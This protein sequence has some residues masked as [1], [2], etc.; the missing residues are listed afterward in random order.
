MIS[1]ALAPII[2]HLQHQKNTFGRL[3]AGST[4]CGIFMDLRMTFGSVNL[5][6]T[7]FYGVE[8]TVY[9]WFEG[10]LRN[11]HQT[12]FGHSYNIH[13]NKFG[14]AYHIYLN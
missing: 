2:Q 5:K 10:Y 1:L 11:R 8:G 13:S 3:E 7:Y 6:E 4:V 9:D 14:V 12:L